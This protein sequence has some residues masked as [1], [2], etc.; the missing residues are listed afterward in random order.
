[1]RGRN[2]VRVRQVHEQRLLLK[3]FRE[4][5]F[6]G[7]MTPIYGAALAGIA[8]A[9][10]SLD[11]AAANLTSPSSD[12]LPTGDVASDFVTLSTAAIAMQAAVKV[13]HVAAETDRSLLDV[14]A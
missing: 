14:I 5:P 6:R 12:G 13:A 8:R 2:H 1:M 7:E 9:A 11:R 10:S 3:S 4:L